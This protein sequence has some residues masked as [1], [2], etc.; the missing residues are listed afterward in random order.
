M[1]IGTYFAPHA[2]S[3]FAS[4]LHV[5]V[6][7]QLVLVVVAFCRVRAMAVVVAFRPVCEKADVAFWPLRTRASKGPFVRDA[8]DYISVG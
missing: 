7:L 4:E 5:G 8:A 1:R 3:E 6:G 2:I